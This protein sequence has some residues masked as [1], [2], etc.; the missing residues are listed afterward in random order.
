MTN[1]Q[2]ENQANMQAEDKNH[3]IMDKDRHQTKKLVYD[4][5]HS[6]TKNPN[7][8]QGHGQMQIEC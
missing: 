1:M 6:Q 2:W 3:S 4:K 7:Q 5:D 8:P